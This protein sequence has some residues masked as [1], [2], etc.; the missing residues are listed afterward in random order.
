MIDDSDR[1]REKEFDL[2]LAS[3]NLDVPSENIEDFI[4]Y[5]VEAVRVFCNH[6]GVDNSI[7]YFKRKLLNVRPF[8]WNYFAMAGFSEVE[9]E[10]RA[11]LNSTNP[12]EARTAAIGLAFLGYQEG[13]DVIIKFIKIYTTKP[14]L[15]TQ[16]VRSSDLTP[17][18]PIINK[19]EL[20]WAK[21]YLTRMK[22]PRAAAILKDYVFFFKRSL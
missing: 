12:N 13:F 18:G 5:G 4:Q 22:D 1:I 16:A 2:L 17:I 19:W 8:E 14:P 6:Y 7:L 3:M 20:D 10:L 11:Y 15:G 21:L 9:L